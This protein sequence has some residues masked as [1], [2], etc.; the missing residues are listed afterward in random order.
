[1][2]CIADSG[3]LIALFGKP[4]ERAWALKELEIRDAPFLTCEAAL[5]EAAHFVD[6]VWLSRLLEDGDIEIGFSAREE[7]FRLCQ[8]LE[9]YRGTMDFADACVVRMSEI[10][11]DCCVFTVD[12][13]HF[14]VYRRFGDK[15][16]PI[17]TPKG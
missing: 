4:A 17:S 9:K 11:S 15:P 10:F 16:I 7:R 13:K 12:S 6:S 14:T 1:M 8:L 3:F 2:V 5:T